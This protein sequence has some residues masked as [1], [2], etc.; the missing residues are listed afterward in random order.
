MSLVQYQPSGADDADHTT[1]Q[2]EAEHGVGPRPFATQRDLLPGRV[3]GT[4]AG[5]HGDEAA[6]VAA[7]PLLDLFRSP[8][9]GGN[10]LACAGKS[11]TA[12]G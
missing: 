2:S 11:A 10:R 9:Q 6:V 12:I 7:Q 4:A 8:G 3:D 1:L 5:A